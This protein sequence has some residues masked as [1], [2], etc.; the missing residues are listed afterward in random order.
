MQFGFTPRNPQET[1]ISVLETGTQ[2]IFGDT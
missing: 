2:A 1:K